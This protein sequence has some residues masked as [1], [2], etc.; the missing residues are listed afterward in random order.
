MPEKNLKEEM[1]NESIAVHYE[2]LRDYTLFNIK[3]HIPRQL[4]EE[5]ENELKSNL[6]KILLDENVP[7]I[8]HERIIKLQLDTMKIVLREF[9]TKD[10]ALVTYSEQKAS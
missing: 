10:P 8:F 5:K 9:T 1:K 6:K 7:E 2:V 4:T 3:Q